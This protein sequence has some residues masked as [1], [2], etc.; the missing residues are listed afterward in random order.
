MNL[1][2]WPAHFRSQLPGV[3]LRH[4]P[5]ASILYLHDNHDFHLYLYSHDD[6]DYDYDD[7][8]DHDDDDDNHDDYDDYGNHGKYFSTLYLSSAP[9]Q[10]KSRWN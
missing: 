2:S 6:H 8:D 3:S 9:P 4:P 7:R 10:T 1:V 5:V